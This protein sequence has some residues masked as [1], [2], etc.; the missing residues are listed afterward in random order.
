MPLTTIL[1]LAVLA[2]L[3][4]IL[5]G[6]TGMG[7]V[8]LI[9]ILTYIGGLDVHLAVSTSMWSFF[10]IAIVGTATYF[11]RSNIDW[12]MAFWISMGIIPAAM[13]GARS[14][15]ALAASAVIVLLA[16]LIVGVGINSLLQQPAVEPRTQPL[17][18][19]ALLPIGIAVG[20]SSALTGAG[21]SILLI[22]LLIFLQVPLLTAI[23][24]SMVT[25]IPL[26]VFSTAGYL[27]Y[28]QVDLFLGTVLGLSAVFGVVVGSQIAH[29]SPT[30][31]LVRI[32]ATTC[33]LT[34]LLMA[35]NSL[36]GIR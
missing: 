15:A 11:K 31:I 27:L 32:V 28:S 10:F 26:V 3:I 22:P 30:I 7:G 19:L 25:V 23:G 2:L 35:T 34:G 29:A 33:I 18:I 4:G 24:T 36:V 6:C 12:R 8:L 13:L 1:L 17:K 9:P 5:A 14:N 20:F 21:G 16:A